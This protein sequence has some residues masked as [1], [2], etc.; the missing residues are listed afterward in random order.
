MGGTLPRGLLIIVLAASLISTGPLASASL[1]R[2]SH[3]TPELWL[4]QTLLK[5]L[6]FGHH[7]GPADREAQAEQAQLRAAVLLLVSC[8]SLLFQASGAAGRG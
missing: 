7:H 6:G 1:E 3:A 2:G 4:Y 8:A 5:Q